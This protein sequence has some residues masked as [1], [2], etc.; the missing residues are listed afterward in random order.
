MVRGHGSTAVDYAEGAIKSRC[1]RV[2]APRVK[3]EVVR[4]A[5]LCCSGDLEGSRQVAGAAL[6]AAERLG[7]VPLRWALAS[8][9]ADIGSVT[10]AGHE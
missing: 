10:Q 9:L 6:D 3:S 4:A 1:A 5:A 2:G 8:L 7:M